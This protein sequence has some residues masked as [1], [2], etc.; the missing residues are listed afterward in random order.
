MAPTTCITSITSQNHM[1]YSTGNRPTQT[2]SQPLSHNT[3]HGNTATSKVSLNNRSK[4]ASLA[5]NRS[6]IALYRDTGK[7]ARKLPGNGTTKHAKSTTS[8]KSIY[9]H[10]PHALKPVHLVA[11]RNARERRRVQ[12]V[13]SAFMRL[14][15]HVPYEPRHKRLSKV[16]TLRVAIA[17]IAHLQDLISQ[18]DRRVA[19]CH[20]QLNVPISDSPSGRS[21]SALINGNSTVPIHVFNNDYSALVT[22]NGRGRGLS[23]A[24]VSQSAAHPP[25][26]HQLRHRG[27]PGSIPGVEDL[28]ANW[29]DELP[30]MVRVKISL[31]FH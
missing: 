28:N 24:N 26:L 1:A 30:Y 17:Y 7:H 11:K 2:T 21:P 14:R 22:G 12:A 4:S 29:A 3:T 25:Q 13:N 9:K 8:K 27:M 19:A 23:G 20:H 6:D 16:K 5:T 15:K 18:H 10:V 31:L